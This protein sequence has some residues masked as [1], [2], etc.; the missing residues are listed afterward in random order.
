MPRI[1]ALKDKAIRMPDT[2]AVIY[3]RYS[4]DSQRETSIEDQLREC[5][6]W[7]EAH[8]FQ[9]VGEY[10]DYAISGRTDDRPQFQKMISD[11]EKGMFS[12]VIMYQTS[13][14][15]RNRYDAALYKH[16]LK[17]AGVAIHYAAMS[18]PD[19]PEG[20]ILEALMEGMDE[21]YSVNLS[22]NIRRGQDGNALKGIAMNAAPI[23]LK[24]NE[25]RMYD[26]DP[27]TGPHVLRAFQM[28]D[29]GRMQVD[30]LAYFNSLGL[31]T[32]K[33]NPF[34]KSSLRTMWRN[35]KYL[36]EYQYRD[37]V[38]PDIIPQLIPDDLFHRVNARIDKNKF[39]NGGR[40][41]SVTEFLLTGKLICGHCG[42]PMIGCSGTGKTGAIHYYYACTSRRREHNCNKANERKDSLEI[43]IVRE[44]IQHVL[45]PAVLSSLIDH[46]MALL[47]KETLEDPILRTLEAEKKTVETA[48]RNL[49]RAIEDGLYTPTTKKRLE[50][51]EQQQSDIT[52]K[53]TIRKSSHPV[54]TREHLQ[55]FLESFRDGD[56]NDPNHRRRVIDALVHS[57]TISDVPSDDDNGKPKRRLQIMYNLTQN[58]TSS[59]DLAA[60]ESSSAVLVAPPH[61]HAAFLKS[62][63]SFFSTVL[64]QRS[65][66]DGVNRPVPE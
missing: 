64:L 66:C 16:R 43:A 12:A 3:A 63:W 39:T 40:A 18:I 36:G 20:I 34:N 60:L 42:K 50:E 49:M 22:Q 1:P 53:I 61:D 37:V 52:S 30:V 5:R 8:E 31:R 27:N 9:I 57:V 14:F 54:I 17:K 21:Y 26:I 51:L 10:C 15:A 6:Q 45:Q 65:V 47:E 11:A 23:G 4:S 7:A 28:I 48:L 32:S 24:I 35:R 2:M 38:I 62:A 46:A 59:I 33:G 25:K 13:R 44:T 55:Y 58:N 19:G 41:R 56:V 29:E